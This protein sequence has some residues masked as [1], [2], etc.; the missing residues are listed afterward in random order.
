MR[1]YNDAGKLWRVAV[2]GGAPKLMFDIDSETMVDVPA[3]SWL[4]NGDLMHV[5]HWKQGTDSAGARRT[6]LAVFDG[7]PRVSVPGEPGGS[8]GMPT[9]AGRW[10]P[11]VRRDASAGIWAVPQT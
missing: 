3:P 4:P 6:E 9:L 10:L 5:V 11:Y 1:V 8:N 7:R 2:D